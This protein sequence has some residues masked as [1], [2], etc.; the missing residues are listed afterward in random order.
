MQD[1]KI[2][3]SVFVGI[4]IAKHAFDVALL[5]QEQ[6]AKL[7]PACGSCWSCLRL[8]EAAGWCWKPPAAGSGVWPES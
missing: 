8:G 3:S 4:D 7:T 6:C 5:P 2:E 1:A